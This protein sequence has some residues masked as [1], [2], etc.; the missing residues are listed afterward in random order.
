MVTKDWLW[1]WQS[2]MLDTRHRLAE[3]RFGVNATWSNGRR[4][5]PAKPFHF[6]ITW[7]SLT[8]HLALRKAVERAS[9]TTSHPVR[10]MKQSS[11]AALAGIPVTPLERPGT[12]S[13][14]D[15]RWEMV[16]PKMVRPDR[17]LKALP[18]APLTDNRNRDIYPPIHIPTLTCFDNTRQPLLSR[19]FAA[20]GRCTRLL[21]AGPTK[22][23][24]AIPL[25]SRL[26]S[27]GLALA[28]GRASHLQILQLSAPEASISVQDSSAQQEPAKD[29]NAARELLLS[30]ITSTL[31]SQSRSADSG[32]KV[33]HPDQRWSEVLIEDAPG[34]PYPYGQP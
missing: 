29:K 16:V 7:T 9:A 5:E 10:E 11:F 32:L 13:D 4:K 15:A 18:T 23:I 6:A 31:R 30:K 8:R 33:S 28:N 34:S 22:T 3:P 1:R 12:R 14:S 21:L 24:D 25:W 19:A 2:Y 26:D 27:P 17:G 20:I